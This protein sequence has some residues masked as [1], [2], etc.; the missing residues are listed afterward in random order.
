MYSTHR[1]RE[2]QVRRWTFPF[3][4]LQFFCLRTTNLS[5]SNTVG[6]RGRVNP[7]R[8]L[9]FLVNSWLV[10]EANIWWLDLNYLKIPGMVDSQLIYGMAHSTGRTFACCILRTE[11]GFTELIATAE[12]G[13]YCVVFGAKILNKT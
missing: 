9:G 6:P 10:W 2:K 3:I 7:A 1:L 13:L 11:R 4:S 12:F 5:F 8:G